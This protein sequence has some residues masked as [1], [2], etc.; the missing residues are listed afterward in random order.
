MKKK[1]ILVVD[2]DLSLLKT[3]QNILQRKG[4]DVET[5]ATGR[6]AIEKFES[7]PYD[8]LLIDI[9]LPDMKGTDLLKV[10]NNSQTRIIKIMITGYPDL[11][12]VIESL[13]QGAHAYIL[14]PVNLEELMRVI[15]EK[16]EKQ[17]K[18]TKLRSE[19]AMIMFGKFLDLIDDKKLWTIADIAHELNTSQYLVERVAQFF[20]RYGFIKYWSIM[21]SVQLNRDSL[22]IPAM[23]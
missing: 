14:K 18:F 5:A 7:H 20:S 16:L 11:D 3:L 21:G 2:D 15:K 1:R 4:Y 13:Y 6:E 23:T 12:P 19:D 17:T 8:V 9:K 10:M 22:K